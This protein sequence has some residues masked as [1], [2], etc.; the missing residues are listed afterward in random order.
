MEHREFSQLQNPLLKHLLSTHISPRTLRY[1]LAPADALQ[2]AGCSSCIVIEQ[3]RSPAT[4]PT[5]PL[6]SPR[7]PMLLLALHPVA[8][9]RYQSTAMR[10]A[11]P[12]SSCPKNN[13]DVPASPARATTPCGRRPLVG[14]D[15]QTERQT[16]TWPCDFRIIL[17]SILSNFAICPGGSDGSVELICR[18]LALLQLYRTSFWSGMQGWVCSPLELRG[19]SIQASGSPHSIIVV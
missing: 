6:F 17:E 1:K 4:P 2:I 19:V 7:P 10:L 14:A 12:S 18:L 15:R 16:N 11:R 9:L 13:S 8:E 3:A 5:R